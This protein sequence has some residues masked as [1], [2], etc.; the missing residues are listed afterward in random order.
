MYNLATIDLIDPGAL[1]VQYR[2]FI[3][4]IITDFFVL[5]LSGYNSS[6]KKSISIPGG[7]RAR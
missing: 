5:K 3:G 4:N 7:S 6:I 2:A 1:C